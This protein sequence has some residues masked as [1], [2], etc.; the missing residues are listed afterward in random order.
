MST[1]TSQRICIQTWP[2]DCKRSNTTADLYFED[3]AFETIAVGL[4]YPLLRFS[5]EGAT[6]ITLAELTRAM[7]WA[8][9]RNG[10]KAKEI[11]LASPRR[12][13]NLKSG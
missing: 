11:K 8:L 10:V 3:Q 4:I 5:D 9:I 7:I 12:P 13:R 2:R 6:P 1:D